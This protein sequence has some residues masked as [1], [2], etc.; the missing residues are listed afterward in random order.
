MRHLCDGI[1]PDRDQCERGNGQVVNIFY[2]R[3]TGV[4]RFDFLLIFSRAGIH[5]QVYC[6]RQ[7][8]EGSGQ[9]EGD[10]ACAYDIYLLRYQVAFLFIL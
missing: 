2:Q 10:I 7:I 6:L 3:D 9:V 8:T 5:S 4:K 1:I